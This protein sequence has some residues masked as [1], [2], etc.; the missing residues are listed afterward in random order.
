MEL[1]EK[2][3]INIAPHQEQAEVIIRHGNAPKPLDPLAP[4]VTNLNGTICAVTEYL[5]KH[6]DSGQFEQK[7]CHILVDRSKV[8]ISLIINEADPYNRGTVTG[9]LICNPKF[10]EFGINSDKRWTPMELGL[11]FK[12]NRSFF[13]DRQT[14]MAL[15]T[16]LMNFTATIN[17]KIERSVSENGNRTDNFVQ[18][19][20]SNL[21]DAFT[22]NIPIFK[23]MPAEIIEVET[24]ASVNGREV[25]FAL[26]S[27][28]AQ[29]TLEELR[30]KVIDEEIAKIRDLT[31]EI[32]II[33]V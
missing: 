31:P 15:V 18:M 23:G 24:F 3:N 27:P 7:D 33:E 29:V 13:Q 8:K 1:Q 2:I 12:M 9:A 10:I 19:V 32:A 11:F 4:I 14:N 25:S 6:K 28:G 26:L 20:N 22:L 17:N 5:K 30:D 16:T 21:P